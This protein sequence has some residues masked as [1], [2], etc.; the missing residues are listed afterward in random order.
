VRNVR[1]ERKGKKEKSEDVKDNPQKTK[2]SAL[3][4]SLLFFH[5]SFVLDTRPE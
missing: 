5:F 3:L 1:E 4:F 2:E